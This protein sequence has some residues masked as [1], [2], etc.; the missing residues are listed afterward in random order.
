MKAL[1]GAKAVEWC[2]LLSRL[3]RIAR[4]GALYP[5]ASRVLQL[6]EFCARVTPKKEQAEVMVSGLS[7]L[8]SVKALEKLTAMRDVATRFL[9]DH[10]AKVSRKSH[11][12]S[13]AL[14]AS[15]LP[16][17]VSTHALLVSK[18]PGPRRFLL[19]HDR[20]VGALGC[21]VR[22]TMSLSD[23]T[24]R[25]LSVDKAEQAR[26]KDPLHLALEGA[27]AENA[28][29]AYLQ[30]KALEGVEVSEVAM[31]QLGPFEAPNLVPTDLLPLRGFL[32]ARPVTGVLHLVLERAANLVAAD[33]SVDPFFSLDVGTQAL[34]RRAAL[35]YHVSRER[36]L[37]CPGDLHALLQAHLKSLSASIIIRSK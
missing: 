7:G 11:G 8:P 35:G 13:T 37:C 4:P 24:G 20:W 21:P 28:E 32:S 2:A 10:G 3:I 29:Q 1:E 5:D 31:G 19:V 36:R 15:D 26:V 27:C 14:A 9:R 12:W 34:Q 22:Y 30:L 17:R 6:L 16:T 18:G 25:W 33:V 23:A